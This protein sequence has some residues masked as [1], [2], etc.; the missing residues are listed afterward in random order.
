MDHSVDEKLAGWSCSRSCGQWLNVQVDTSD[1]WRSSGVSTGMVL[2][3]IFSGDM[4]SGIECTLSE[5]ADNTKLCG[6]VDS[7]EGR[8][9]VQRTLT[10]LKGGPE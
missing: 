1:Q 10:G 7:L 8:D 5:L 9:A 2:F 4:D 3:N 6:A